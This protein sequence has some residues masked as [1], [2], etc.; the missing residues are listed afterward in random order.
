MP[1]KT[2]RLPDGGFAHV[3]FSNPPRRRCAFCQ[4]WSVALCDGPNPKRKSKTCDRPMCW[5]H[6]TMV[7]ADK[8][9][10]PTCLKTRPAPAQGALWQDRSE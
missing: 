9:L 8:D 10:C 2:I 1:C 3:R 6:R 5:K 4:D 7:G